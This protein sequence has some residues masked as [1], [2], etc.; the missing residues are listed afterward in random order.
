MAPHL[1]QTSVIK[2]SWYLLI[3]FMIQSLMANRQPILVQH[4]NEKHDNILNII[5]IGI[6]CGSD[7]VNIDILAPIPIG[8]NSLQ[9]GRLGSF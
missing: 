3:L 2:S 7:I 8:R 5:Y 1:G 9:N 6:K 4:L